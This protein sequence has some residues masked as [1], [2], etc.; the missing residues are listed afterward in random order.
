MQS[1]PVTAKVVKSNPVH[2]EVYL[3]Q[4]YVIKFDSDLQQVGGFLQVLLISSINKTDC[5]DITDIM[6]KVALNTMNQPT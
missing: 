6:L 3:I 4:Y 5:H 2:G 1:V